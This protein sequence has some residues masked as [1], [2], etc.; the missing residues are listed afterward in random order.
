MSTYSP[1]LR[2][3]LITTGTEAG[4]WGNTTNTNLGTVI[5]DAISGYTTVTIS[6]A[7]QA[8]TAV[9]G[10]VDQARNAMIELAGA[11]SDF[12]IY[13]PPVSKQYI[14]W[15][16]SGYTATIRNSTAANGTTPIPGSTAI[17]IANG[18]K[19]VVFSNG[20]SFYDV[21][22]NGIIGT[23]PIANGGTGQTT[24]QAAINALVGTQT[25]NR[26]LRSDGTNSTLAQ[27][28]VATDVT[29]ILAA[30]NGGT[31]LSSLGTNVSTALGINAN[32]TAGGFVRTTGATT[33][34][35]VLTTPLIA[36]PTMTA[37][38]LGTPASGTLTNCDGLPLTTGVTG[39]LAVANGGTGVTTST[40]TG[41]TVRSVSPTFTGTPA[42]PTASAGTNTTQL[43]T[44][45]FV[46]AAAQS[47][48]PVGSIYINATNS[49]NPGTLL[50]FGTW[51]AF[52]AGRVPVGFNASNTLFDTAEETGGSADAV[53]VNHTHTAT[54]TITDPGHTHNLPISNDQ[55]YPS[56]SGGTRQGSGAV[57]SSA[58]TGIT[59]ATTVASAGVSGANANYQPYI[60]VYMWKRTA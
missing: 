23:L 49:T 21:K 4:T 28:N 17:T 46:Q 11:P 57:T 33:V 7:S 54:T 32:G 24:R 16:N 9:D 40:G 37:P 19:V 47:L 58:T 48:Y 10:L 2:I 39:T 38:V 52:G 41:S 30:T 43:A 51:T 1:D 59:A 55:G 18:D 3:T 35:M 20:S 12:T 42:A 13:A 29:G 45:A 25:A 15:N 50:G 44:T 27:V 6:S 8:L 14:I 22:A 60:T 34:D 5:E 26:V 31:G 36:G 56:G 53:V